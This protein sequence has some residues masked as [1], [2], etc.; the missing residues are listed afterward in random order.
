MP[1]VPKPSLIIGEKTSSDFE[2]NFSFS[3]K[4]YSPIIIL[5]H[6]DVESV[7][8]GGKSYCRVISFSAQRRRAFSFL[9]F[10]S[11][12]SVS[13]VRFCCFSST[14]AVASERKEFFFLVKV[15]RCRFWYKVDA[16]QPAKRQG[17]AQRNTPLTGPRTALLTTRPRE[18]QTKHKRKKNTWY[19]PLPRNERKR[20][21]R[22]R[23]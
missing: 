10:S 12:I 13:S 3:L 17:N 7:W 4:S 8:Y 6:E 11:F 23:K 20:K 2:K 21:S 18:N 16:Q 22:S 14:V 9:F 19:R 1:D 15:F 5:K